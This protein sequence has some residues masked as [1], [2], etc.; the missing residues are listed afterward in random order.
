MWPVLVVGFTQA[1]VTIGP[2]GL[3]QHNKD[4][5]NVAG[6]M[7][8]IVPTPKVEG[9][10]DVVHL[11]S[12]RQQLNNNIDSRCSVLCIVNVVNEA[13]RPRRETSDISCQNNVSNDTIPT[14]F[15]CYL[16]VGCDLGYWCPSISSYITPTRPIP[17]WTWLAQLRTS[18]ATTPKAIREHLYGKHYIVLCIRD[19][20]TLFALWG[21]S[22][23][24]CDDCLDKFSQIRIRN[25]T[26]SNANGYV[27]IYHYFFDSFYKNAVL[28]NI[29][30]W[31]TD[32]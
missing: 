11:I 6:A 7:L 9:V 30:Y 16:P 20:R 12:Q 5:N 8:C 28:C 25:N 23:T 2:N 4:H 19:H 24:S 13:H 15:W 3:Q 32:K 1:A 29:R 18:Q 27:I 21:G 14:A 26:W 10:N 17:H 22:Q 31:Y